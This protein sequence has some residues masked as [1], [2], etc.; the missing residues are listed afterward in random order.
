MLEKI[1]KIK[2]KKT[3]LTNELI[4]TFIY[5]KDKKYDQELIYSKIN[6]IEYILKFIIKSELNVLD[7]SHEN[8]IAQ[9]KLQI[10][11]SSEITML[12][13]IVYSKSG[14]LNQAEKV[15]LLKTAQEAKINQEYAISG[16][17]FSL[18]NIESAIE[19]NDQTL[20]DPLSVYQ[21]IR[22]DISNSVSELDSEESQL[23]NLHDEPALMEVSTKDQIHQIRKSIERKRKQV[24]KKD[25]RKN[26]L[27]NDQPED[28]IQG[29]FE[30]VELGANKVFGTQQEAEQSVLNI[31]DA[32][33]QE[34]NRIEEEIYLK[35][36]RNAEL[37]KQSNSFFKPKK[38]QYAKKPQNLHTYIPS[39]FSLEYIK[40]HP[41]K[42]PF[43]NT[44]IRQVNN[45]Q[46]KNENSQK[47]VFEIKNENT[48]SDYLM[49]NKDPGK[50][51]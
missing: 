46:E 24:Q 27:L 15:R 36:S 30:S 34:N 37:F 38:K 49:M 19:E 26:D 28:F 32:F 48:M 42:Y 21:Y 10:F 2:I 47:L 31:L 23:Q 12:E 3:N 6:F 17:C 4:S 51:Y 18:Y 35:S 41:V 40:S 1:E 50:I 44:I 29:D 33:I 7:E 22:E 13:D 8:L 25:A 20:I 43:I 5:K 14:Y 9:Y 16:R 45:I 11:K 39:Q